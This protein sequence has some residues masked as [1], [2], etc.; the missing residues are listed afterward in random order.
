MQVVLTIFYLMWLIAVLVFLFLIYRQTRDYVQRAEKTTL[1][2]SEL[3]AQAAQ[4]SAEVAA[5]LAD[6]LEAKEAH[7]A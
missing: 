3:T 5:K 7:N 1:V 2:S 6:M 4:K